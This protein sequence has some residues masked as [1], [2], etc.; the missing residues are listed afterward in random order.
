MWGDKFMLENLKKQKQ[1]KQPFHHQHVHSVLSP[2]YME[3]ILDANR[4]ASYS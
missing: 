3:A 4:A 1:K 2:N